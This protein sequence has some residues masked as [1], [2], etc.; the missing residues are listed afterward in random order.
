MVLGADAAHETGD[1]ATSDRLSSKAYS[2]ATMSGLLSSGSARPRMAILAR[3]TQR[4]GEHARDRH[5][6]VGRLM[7]LVEAHAID[8]EPVG[9]LHLVEIVAIE[10]RAFP[11]NHTGGPI[12]T[13]VQSA[14]GATARN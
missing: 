6:A 3:F 5:H 12:N 7:M 10:L 13:S 9:K 4:A 14:T 2:S 8:A 1:E 11:A